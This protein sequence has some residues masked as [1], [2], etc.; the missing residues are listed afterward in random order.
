M[1]TFGFSWKIWKSATPIATAEEILAYLKEAADEQGIIDKI[2]FNTNVDTA[3]FSSAD[4]R[5][6]P[7]LVLYPKTHHGTV[8]DPLMIL[9]N[10]VE[11]V[12][13][14]ESLLA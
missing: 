13:C 6:A 1:Y 3:N 2:K 10:R 12:R 5:Q 14:Q 7:S 4:N 8:M 11:T 9:V